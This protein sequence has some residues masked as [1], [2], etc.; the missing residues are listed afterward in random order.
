MR[1]KAPAWTSMVKAIMDEG[2]FK[3]KKKKNKVKVA[4]L[5]RKVLRARR[6]T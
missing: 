3:K 4:C 6:E 5:E 2:K 1:S